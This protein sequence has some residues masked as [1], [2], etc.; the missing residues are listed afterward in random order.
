M[1]KVLPLTHPSPFLPGKSFRI[2]PIKIS[3]WRIKIWESN[4]W[5]AGVDYPVGMQ[6]FLF[7]TQM[8]GKFVALVLSPRPLSHPQSSSELVSTKHCVEQAVKL[9]RRNDSAL[10]TLPALRC[11]KVFCLSSLLSVLGWPSEQH[12]H[13]SAQ[14]TETLKLWIMSLHPVP[15]TPANV[16]FISLGGLHFPHVLPSSSSGFPRASHNKPACLGSPAGWGG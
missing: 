13:L 1:D 3:C 6:T 11:S 5:V 10:P 12:L 9:L 16:F 4:C 15:F 7:S 2:L 14:M 8:V